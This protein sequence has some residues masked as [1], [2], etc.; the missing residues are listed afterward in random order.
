MS[1]A[2]RAQR[3][4]VPP[5]GRMLDMACRCCGARRVELVIDLT[6][7]PH[8][9]RLVPRLLAKTDTDPAY[10]L[11]VGFCHDCTLVQ[12]D[13]TIPKEQMFSDYP[14]V[15]GTTKTLVEHFRQ[16]AA[17]LVEVYGLK[18]VDRV[19]DIGS[20][21]GS[22]LAQYKPFGLTALGVEAAANVAKIA[23]ANGVRP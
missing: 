23:N 22:W 7:Q 9:N 12:I 13:H 15:L 10:P 1:E 5:P 11:R 20:N 3:L 14:Y 21:D 19:V 17:R 6:D 8:C 18:G 4:A 16:T 2:A